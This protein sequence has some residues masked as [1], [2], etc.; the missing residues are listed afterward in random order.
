MKT[1]AYA[2][3]RTFFWLNLAV[4]TV[5][6]LLLATAVEYHS[7]IAGSYLSNYWGIVPIG[8]VSAA[9]YRYFGNPRVSHKPNEDQ[10]CA[11]ESLVILVITT[12]S[13]LVLVPILIFNSVH[14]PLSLAACVFL[15]ALPL[16]QARVNA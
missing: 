10:N 4:S 1:P 5:G 6:F 12:I 8:I 14:R 3:P 11:G 2:S 7:P 13:N 9:V 16:A 15:A